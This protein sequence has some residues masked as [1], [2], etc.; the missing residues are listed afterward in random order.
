MPPQ[1]SFTF[2][3]SD[4]KHLLPAKN[5]TFQT[6]VPPPNKAQAPPRPQENHPPVFMHQDA[7]LEIS[8]DGKATVGEFEKFLLLSK[9]VC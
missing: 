5:F 4:G 8:R 6:D 1:F 2:T 3:V 9:T 7:V